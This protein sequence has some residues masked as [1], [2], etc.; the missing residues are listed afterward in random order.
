MSELCV[1]SIKAMADIDVSACKDIQ[2]V[3]QK[4]V[5]FLRRKRSRLPRLLAKIT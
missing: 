4:V 1:I 2:A 5:S 3:E